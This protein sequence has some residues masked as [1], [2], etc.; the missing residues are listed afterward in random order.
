MWRGLRFGKHDRA[1]VAVI[2][3][4][5]CAVFLVVSLSGRR[6]H[7]VSPPAREQIAELRNFAVSVSDTMHGSL[8]VEILRPAVVPRAGSNSHLASQLVNGSSYEAIR[9]LAAGEQVDLNCGDTSLLKR[10][11]GVGSVLARRIVRYGELLG[12]YVSP[13]QVAE[14][15]G[16]S[17][18]MEKWFCVGNVAPRKINLNRATYAEM[19]RHPYFNVRQVRAVIH[20]RDLSGRIS[21]LAQMRLDTVFAEKDINRLA[22]YVEF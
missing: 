9:K 6:V 15:Y 11:P 18:G 13:V 1:V 22:P 10:V 5:L 16:L 2:A 21:G 12:G 20:R 14:V 17:S 3:A 7:R 4:A 19:L 8:P